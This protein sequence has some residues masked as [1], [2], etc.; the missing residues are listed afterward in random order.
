MKKVLLG[1]ERKVPD[2]L[3]LWLRLNAGGQITKHYVV[4]ID[5][6]RN[7]DWGWGSRGL[8]RI[9]DIERNLGGFLW[10]GPIP[11]IP[12][13]VERYIDPRNI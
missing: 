11:K 12:H 9:E 5:G 7:I 8:A 4:E 6:I 1:W 10:L 13:D 3:G 2:A